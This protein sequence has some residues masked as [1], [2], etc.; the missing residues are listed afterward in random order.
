MEEALKGQKC[1]NCSGYAFEFRISFFAKLL[2]RYGIINTHY[3]YYSGA[4]YGRCACCLPLSR[5][6]A[7]RYCSALTYI[8]S[9]C[10]VGIVALLL[11]LC[12]A[13]C[14]S[15][16]A[17][18]CATAALLCAVCGATAALLCAVQQAE[19]RCCCAV[20]SAV[21]CSSA[22][23]VRCAAALLL[24]LLL[25]LLFAVQWRSI[26]YHGRCGLLPL[27]SPHRAHALLLL[28]HI[29]LLHKLIM[30]IF[31]TYVTSSGSIR[32]CFLKLEACHQL[33]GPSCWVNV[34]H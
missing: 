25:A 23:A 9:C 13:L 3:R 5:Y 34:I 7:S 2:T 11:L 16:S 29:L 22:A 10:A 1:T 24:A 27:P 28:L 33:M 32:I 12:C 21:L 31:K 15:S 8:Q 19:Q 4:Q 26:L 30:H 17:V 20:S 6:S 14:S 18:R